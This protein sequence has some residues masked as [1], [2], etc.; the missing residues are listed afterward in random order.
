LTLLGARGYAFSSRGIC[1]VLI[2]MGEQNLSAIEDIDAKALFVL[3]NMRDR[4]IDRYPTLPPQNADD[5]ELQDYMRKIWAQSHEAENYLQ[6][7][8]ELEETKVILHN[9]VSKVLKRGEKID[10]LV[11][12]SNNLSIHSKAFYNQ[13][14]NYGWVFRITLTSPPRRIRATLVAKLCN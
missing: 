5:S 8:R 13:V 12:K 9:T 10:N 7:Q 6:I 14:F 11:F 4:F 1:G 3:R 2:L